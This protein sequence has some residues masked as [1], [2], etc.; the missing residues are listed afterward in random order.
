MEIGYIYYQMHVMWYELD[1]LPETLLSI[2]SASEYSS[3][4]IKYDIAINLQTYIESPNE[5]ID[6]NYIYELI[7]S[8]L[9]DANIEL[10]T[11]DLPFYNIGDWRREKYDIN[12]SYTVWGESD[13]LLPINFFHI[14]CNLN[15]EIKPHIVSFAS[16]KMWD[17]S[18]KCVEHP[19]S[20]IY[21]PNDPDNTPEPYWCGHYIK[22]EQL[23]TI[24]DVDTLKLD[25]INPLKIDGANLCLSGGIDFKFIPDNMHFC[26]EDMCAQIKFQQN[27]IVQY[28]ISNIMKGH[29]YGHP[30]K[31]TNTNN[32]RNDD[33]YKKYQKESYIAMQTFIT[34]GKI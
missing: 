19:L 12:A 13:C 4:P 14:L 3:L 7:K 17:D 24:N 20:T 16:R 27:G 2:K 21:N 30:L 23:N 25:V 15:I 22:Q 29:N 11:N 26:Y 6:Q 18:W 5:Q 28:H 32:T 31:R 10:I 9:P 8:Y 34:N 33:T 1:M